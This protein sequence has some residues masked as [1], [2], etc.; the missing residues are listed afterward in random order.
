MLTDP[1][2]SSFSPRDEHIIHPEMFDK[3]RA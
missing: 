2:L 1:G 3:Q